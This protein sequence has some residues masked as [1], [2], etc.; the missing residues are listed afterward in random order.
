MQFISW[1]DMT[2]RAFPIPIRLIQRACVGFVGAPVHNKR[3]GNENC[4]PLVL[5]RERQRNGN[6]GQMLSWKSVFESSPSTR[7][8]AVRIW[9]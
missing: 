2:R 5:L 6:I 7:R 8:V 4:N 1:L 3:K 9:L